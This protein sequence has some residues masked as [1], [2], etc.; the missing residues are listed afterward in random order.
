MDDLAQSAQG[1]RWAERLHVVGA[2][3]SDGLRRLT[4]GAARKP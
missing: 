2:S 3:L 4:P 1:R